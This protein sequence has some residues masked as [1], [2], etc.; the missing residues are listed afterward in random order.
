[1]TVLIFAQLQIFSFSYVE[2][3]N[4]VAIKLDENK[5]SNFFNEQLTI[6]CK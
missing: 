6:E 1:M 3:V 5:H 4:K 2:M